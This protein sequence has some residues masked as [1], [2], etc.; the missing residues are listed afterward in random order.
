MG[1]RRHLEDTR[2]DNFSL[3]P[4]AS[5]LGA[6]ELH[7]LVFCFALFSYIPPHWRAAIMPNI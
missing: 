1:R 2:E 7:M 4:V 3:L 5:L 6:F